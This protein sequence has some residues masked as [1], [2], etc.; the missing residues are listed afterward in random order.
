M[1]PMIV[2]IIS[3]TTKA[4]N[5]LTKFKDKANCTS[6]SHIA[7]ISLRRK[8]HQLHSIPMYLIQVFSPARGGEGMVEAVVNP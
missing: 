3:S 2:S 6:L 1:R 4:R 5:D 8:N 7:C